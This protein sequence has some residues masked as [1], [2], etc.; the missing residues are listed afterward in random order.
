MASEHIDVLVDGV[1]EQEDIGPDEEQPKPDIPAPCDVH[2]VVD[3]GSGSSDSSSDGLVSGQDDGGADK[4]EVPHDTHGGEECDDSA[5]DP[6]ATM[7][8]EDEGGVDLG[9]WGNCA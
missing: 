6:W 9:P 2:G 5:T 7:K 8:P 1:S 4:R 3:D